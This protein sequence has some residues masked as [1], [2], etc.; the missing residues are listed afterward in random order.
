MPGGDWRRWG[1]RLVAGSHA[2][3]SQQWRIARTRVW[4]PAIVERPGLY[5]GMFSIFG[6][7]NEKDFCTGTS[8]YIGFRVQPKFAASKGACLVAATAALRNH[9]KRPLLYEQGTKLVTFL[10]GIDVDWVVRTTFLLPFHVRL[11]LSEILRL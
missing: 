2:S 3:A 5:S 7:T 8:F 1:H 11:F 9:P 4:G 10:Y 6:V